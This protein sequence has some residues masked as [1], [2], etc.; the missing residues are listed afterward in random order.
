MGMV[1]LRVGRI[2]RDLESTVR[3]RRR[4]N[5]DHFG[6]QALVDVF[7]VGEVREDALRKVG[8]V[9][10]GSAMNPETARKKFQNERTITAWDRKMFR[11]RPERARRAP[12]PAA[13]PATPPPTAGPAPPADQRGG[14]A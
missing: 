11:T 14:G 3:F 4:I 5:E 2:E 10:P 1:V 8:I 13:T 6:S 7:R 12:P 9:L